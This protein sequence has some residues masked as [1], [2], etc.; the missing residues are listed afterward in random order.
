VD[1]WRAEYRTVL[2]SATRDQGNWTSVRSIYRDALDR[3]LTDYPTIDLSTG[4]REEFTD[5]WQ[6][7]VPWPD[8]MP[9]LSRLEQ[10]FT[11]ATLSNADVCTVVNISK[12]GA[13]PWDAIFTA[14]MAGVFK[15][16]AEVYHMA[17]RFLGLTPP[18]IM[19]VACHKYDI[20]AESALG[21]RTAF[22]ARPL[23]LGVGAGPDVSYDDEFERA[24]DLPDL[25]H[26]VFPLGRAWW[27]PSLC[28]VKEFG[29]GVPPPINA[30][31]GLCAFERN[32]GQKQIRHAV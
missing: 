17:A 21:F 31:F 27:F 13:L 30:L 3:L 6:R 19:M 14:E 24:A 29:G 11:L 28:P 20:R 22:V 4:Q 23:E 32:V 18:E 7:L 16:A 10:S 26:E 8:V 12:R 2:E 9:G 5:A 15:P 1:R 25:C